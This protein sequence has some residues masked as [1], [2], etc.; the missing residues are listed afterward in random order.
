MYWGRDTYKSKNVLRERHLQEWQCI[1]REIATRVRM[2]WERD[3]CRSDN[4]LRERYLQCIE[5]ETLAGVTMH[6][7]RD[8]YKSKNGLRERHLHG[9]TYRSN[10][11]LRERHVHEWQVHTQWEHALADKA[12]AILQ[13]RF[14]ICLARN[15]TLAGR[16]IATQKLSQKN[17]ARSAQR[18]ALAIEAFKQARLD[19]AEWLRD[20]P[21]SPSPFKPSAPAQQPSSKHAASCAPAGGAAALG[22]GAD[23][24]RIHA[25]VLAVNDLSQQQHAHAQQQ[26]AMAEAN[27]RATEDLQ[28]GLQ[29]LDAGMLR[30]ASDIQSLAHR[31]SDTH[32]IL[33]S[34]EGATGAR[35]APLCV[36][37]A[38]IY[39]CIYVYTYMDTYIH[40]YI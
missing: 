17:K 31:V 32:S 6:W 33:L 22:D 25:L 16:S 11:V 35:S 28:L 13:A 34:L 15:N 29:H 27:L 12:A 36:L 21:D 40:I 19:F 37:S 9:D 3:T 26:L 20:H 38:C 23:A 24:T 4:V 1:E 14:R 8:T 30:A 2:Y 10:N 18:M 5:R 39:I 7:R